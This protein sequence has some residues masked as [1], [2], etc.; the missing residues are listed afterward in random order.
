VANET[1]ILNYTIERSVNQV[2]FTALGNVA[3][4][5]DPANT[6]AYKFTD[7]N[8]PA[9]ISLFYR[10]KITRKNGDKKYSDVIK[11]KKGSIPFDASVSPS[12]AL[13][14]NVQLNIT[15]PA[16]VRLTITVFNSNNQQVHQE[17]QSIN[18]GTSRV[19]LSIKTLA[20][21]NYTIAVNNGEKEIKKRF[22]IN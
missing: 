21:G 10:L 1:D 6:S 19:P 20:A 4:I 7:K 5:N 17:Q 14:D 3:A 16:S 9:S 8:L 22:V 2:N 15:S 13:A 18:A 12:P 11:I